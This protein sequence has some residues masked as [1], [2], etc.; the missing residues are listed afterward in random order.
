MKKKKLARRRGRVIVAMSGGVDSSVAAAILKNRG[1]DVIGIFMLMHKNS[2]FQDAK[3]IAKKLEIDFKILDVRK[4]F[5]KRVVD[6]FIQEYK[7]GRTPNPCVE[8]NK[9]IKFRF[10]IEKALQLKA[11][12]VATGHYVRPRR[13]GLGPTRL[14]TAKD[15]KKDQTYFLWTLN[16]KQLK[17]SLFPVGD[18][19]KTQIRAMAKKFDLSV[20]EK[21]DSQEI[22]FITDIYEFLSSR[23]PTNKGPIITIDGKKMGEHKGLIFYTIGQ[24]KGIEIGGVGPFY[25]V[26]KDFKKNALIVAQGDFNQALYKKEMIVKNVNWLRLD[27]LAGRNKFRCKIKIRYLHKSVPATVFKVYGSKFKVL[28]TSPQ[29]AITPGQ[30]AVFYLKDEALGG[31]VIE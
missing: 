27:L 13:I 9:W 10:L 16:Q 18:Y 5:K 22:C 25:V 28:F 8:C 31:G 3:I 20:F 19:T 11:D 1:Y 14:L 12:Y 29:R 7:K 17:K 4:E 23:I 6:Y 26:D 30:S 21:K 24:R 15:T 2:D